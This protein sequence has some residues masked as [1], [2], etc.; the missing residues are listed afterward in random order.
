MNQ[1][2]YDAYLA[3]IPV[4]T[5]E[6]KIDELLTLMRLTGEDKNQALEVI[7]ILAPTD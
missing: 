7:N 3:S 6:E 5:Q 4:K 2:E 1:T